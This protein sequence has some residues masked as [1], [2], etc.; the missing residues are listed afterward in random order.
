MLFRSFS[1]FSFFLL[2]SLSLC[3]PGGHQLYPNPNP[4]Q[5]HTHTTHIAP[6]P[7][8]GSCRRHLLSPDSSGQRGQPFLLPRV[9]PLS[10]HVLHLRRPRSS[11]SR[12]A[13]ARACAA[14]TS[15]TTQPR[16]RAPRAASPTS[17]STPPLLSFCCGSGQWGISIHP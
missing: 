5:P 11:S 9:T 14:R 1:N 4:R 7:N 6:I 2:R 15:T 17:P 12:R 3:V 16:S 8:L 13:Q 10:M